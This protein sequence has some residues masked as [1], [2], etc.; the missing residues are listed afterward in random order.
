[1]VTGAYPGVVLDRDLL[2]ASPHGGRLVA[3]R[4]PV[5]IHDGWL[6]LRQYLT[7]ADVER[8]DRLAD[9]RGLGAGVQAASVAAARLGVAISRAGIGTRQHTGASPVEHLGSGASTLVAE[10]RFL[11]EVSRRLRSSFVRDAV[12]ELVH[13]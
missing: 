4:I 13:G 7:A 5:E 1:V 11:C 3:E 9:E 2:A 10:V 8:I 12:E 6:Q